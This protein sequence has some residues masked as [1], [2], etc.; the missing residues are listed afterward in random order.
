VAQKRR[1]SYRSC[2]L[3]LGF[4][5]ETDLLTVSKESIFTCSN[6]TLLADPTLPQQVEVGQKLAAARGRTGL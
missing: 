2:S 1:L 4:I 3:D 5:P 6:S